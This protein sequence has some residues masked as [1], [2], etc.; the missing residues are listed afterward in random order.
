MLKERALEGTM[1]RFSLERVS[2]HIT[3]SYTSYSGHG[4]LPL[5]RQIAKVIR[6]WSTRKGRGPYSGLIR[7]L[8]YTQKKNGFVEVALGKLSQLKYRDDLDRKSNPSK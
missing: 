7:S 1:K 2:I 5:R 8:I 6:F 4:E 3:Q